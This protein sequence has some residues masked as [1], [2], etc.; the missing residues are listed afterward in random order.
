MASLL[1][2]LLDEESNS[3]ASIFDERR[4]S[5]VRPHLSISWLSNRRIAQPRIER[6][7]GDDLRE[8]RHECLDLLEDFARIADDE[9]VRT[10][11]FHHTPSLSK[12]RKP[13]LVLADALASQ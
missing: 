10:R 2:S 13:F 9:I 3:R 11:E 6:P 7:R 1:Q 4:C 12:R 5:A 8:G